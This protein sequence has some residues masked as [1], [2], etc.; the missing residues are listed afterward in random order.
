MMNVRDLLFFFVRYYW[1]YHAL[2]F[3][4]VLTK[5]SKIVN[6]NRF[7]EVNSMNNKKEHEEIQYVRSQ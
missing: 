2:G 4:I 1:L 6:R 3:F 5:Q 7:D